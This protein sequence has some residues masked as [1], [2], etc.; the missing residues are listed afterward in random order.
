MRLNKDQRDGLAKVC[1]N[2]ATALML[3]VILGGWI[4]EKIGVFAIGNL[5]LSSV[6]LVTLATLLRNKGGLHGD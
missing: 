2:L 3:A 4:E 5:L 6:G 1:D